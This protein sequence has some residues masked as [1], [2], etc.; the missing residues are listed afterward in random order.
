MN[1][2]PITYPQVKLGEQ[3]FAVRYRAGDVV[4]MA[5]DGIEIGEV[6]SLKNSESLNRIA[7]MLHHGIAHSKD[8]P[9]KEILDLI[10]LEDLAVF[11]NAINLALSKVSPQAQTALDEIKARTAK[12]IADAALLA[13]PASSQ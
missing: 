4:R 6:I 7:T 9:A 8:I 2:D 3:V 5:Q 12:S 10:A 1:P 13:A 11:S